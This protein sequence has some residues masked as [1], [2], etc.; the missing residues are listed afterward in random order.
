MPV[1]YGKA[2]MATPWGIESTVAPIMIIT[3]PEAPNGVRR[4]LI[5]ME[6]ALALPGGAAL[7]ASANFAFRRH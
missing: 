2:A 1:A 5:F 3:S 4:G 6:A 7:S